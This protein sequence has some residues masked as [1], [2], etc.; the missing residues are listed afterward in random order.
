MTLRAAGLRAVL[1]VASCGA[2]LSCGAAWA[3]TLPA[4][5]DAVRTDMVRAVDAQRR[6]AGLPALAPDARLTRAAQA[7]ACDMAETAQMRH[8]GSDGSKMATRIRRTGYR[9]AQANENV[10]AGFQ[11]PGQAVAAWMASAGHRAN[12]LAAGTRDVGMG[13]A[14]SEDGTLYWAMVAARSQ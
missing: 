11:D 14:L 9:F 5:I 13:V 12:I 6:E 4:G 7:H 2:A 3:C 8:T 1:A 10:G